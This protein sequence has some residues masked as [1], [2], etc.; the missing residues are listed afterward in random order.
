MNFLEQIVSEYFRLQGHRT[1]RRELWPDH[2]KGDL[3]VLAF[4]PMTKTLTHIE[5]GGNGDRKNIE[6][7]KEKKFERIDFYREHYG[8]MNVRCIA[9]SGWGKESSPA[10]RAELADRDIE[11]MSVGE[12][13]TGIH[14]EIGSNWPPEK[15][16]VPESLPILRGIQEFIRYVKRKR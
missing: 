9:I 8:A 7:L 10:R 16:A 1:A 12:L 13:M 14:K 3:D 11:L 4:N 5:C 6:D 15:R 2:R